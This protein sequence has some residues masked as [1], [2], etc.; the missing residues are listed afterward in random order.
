MLNA[1]MSKYAYGRQTME[2]DRNQVMAFLDEALKISGLKSISRLATS[3]TPIK[4]AASTLN[5]YYYG[6]TDKIGLVTLNK[7]AIF[8]GFKSYEDYISRKALYKKEELVSIRYYTNHLQ[9]LIMFDA[10]SSL[11]EVSPPP[12]Y[13]AEGVSAAVVRGDSL[14]PQLEDGWLL[15]FK[16]SSHGVPEEC[17]GE[18]SIVKLPDGRLLVKIIEKSS[19]PELFH[20]ASKSAVQMMYEEKV[21]WASRII[22]IRPV[23]KR[24][25]AA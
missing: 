11:E 14:Q 5:R 24:R 10:Q 9:E 8:V 19:F 17:L 13:Y 22:D 16:K 12:G 6:R 25:A 1:Q 21:E 20:L 23:P 18:L 2:I 15:F 3:C 7:I 4:V